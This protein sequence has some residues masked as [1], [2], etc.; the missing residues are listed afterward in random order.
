[1][2]IF[3]GWYVVEFWM[4]AWETVKNR[5]VLKITPTNIFP[6]NTFGWTICWTDCHAHAK[7]WA[8][9]QKSS[10]FYTFSCFD[11]KG[12]AILMNH[13]CIICTVE[14]IWFLFLQKQKFTENLWEYLV[15]IENSKFRENSE[16]HFYSSQKINKK[17]FRLKLRTKLMSVLKPF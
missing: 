14:E 5:R 17:T 8:K 16:I 3:S 11:Q 6:Q 4:V 10:W 9:W 2:I 15:P 13:L 7:S 12:N 1:M